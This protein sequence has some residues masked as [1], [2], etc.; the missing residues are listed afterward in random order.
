MKMKWKWILSCLALL[1]PM[2]FGLILWNRLPDTMTTHWGADGNA[3]GLSGKAFVVFVLPLVMLALHVI[4]L[5]ITAKDPGNRKQ[6]KKIL[7]VTFWIMPI[8]S[9]LCHTFVYAAALGM[10]WDPEYLIIPVM[11]LMFVILGNYLPK[12]RQNLTFGIKLTWTVRDEENWNAT[13][14]FGG[15]L[16][17][18]GG[19]LLLFTALLPEELM[20]FAMISILLILC[21]APILYSYS[22]YR[23]KKKAGKSMQAS[24]HMPKNSK[25]VAVIS[26]VMGVLILGLCGVLMGTGDIAF[27]AEEDAV[28][29]EASY[30]DDIR[31][32]YAS[33]D[34]MEYRTDFDPG[35]R[36]N[37]FG[38]PRLSMGTFENEEYGRYTLY[39][40]TGGE[41]AVILTV[42]GETLVL[43]C[44]TRQ[45]TESLYRQILDAWKAQ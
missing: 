7:S 26:C 32:P 12:T 2:A 45:E 41:G 31:I 3:D 21:L 27:T 30:Y 8:V 38:S 40:Y 24:V 23:K 14:R 5:L 35:L 44:K 9:I 39:A 42:E 36:K 43:V 10:S 22:F 16:W 34:G 20:I 6:N 37:G 1:L 29:V 17:V 33:I 28:S 11:A 25:L 13:H 19:I 15:K 4:C 18:A